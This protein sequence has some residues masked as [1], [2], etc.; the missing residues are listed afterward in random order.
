MKEKIDKWHSENEGL[1]N[2]STRM[3]KFLDLFLT[4]KKQK[5][6]EDDI[7]EEIA[8]Y[9]VGKIKTPINLKDSFL[10]IHLMELKRASD[11]AFNN[12]SGFIEEKVEQVVVEDTKKDTDFYVKEGEKLLDFDRDLVEDKKFDVDVLDMLGINVE[13]LSNE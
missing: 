6:K 7:S 2:P 8:L 12:K 5:Y 13:D 10:N 11:M 3:L 1:I 4:L 9:I